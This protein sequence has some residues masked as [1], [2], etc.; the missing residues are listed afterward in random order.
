MDRVV[1]Q[2][3]LQPCA[4]LFVSICLRHIY[5]NAYVCNWPPHQPLVSTSEMII[6]G[7]AQLLIRSPT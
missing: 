5:M 1:Q 6:C 3:A 7:M 2:F 4:V